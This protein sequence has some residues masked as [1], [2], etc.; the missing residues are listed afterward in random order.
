MMFK[1]VSILS[2][3]LTILIAGLIS[4]GALS[5]CSSR[6]QQNA[7]ET[8]HS[9][10]EDMENAAEETGEAAEEGADETGEAVEG[11]GD[12]VE[13]KTDEGDDPGKD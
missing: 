11:A 10:G 3:F 12:K 9:A 4:G 13:E 7:K 5:G 2:S 1:R 8:T 6:T